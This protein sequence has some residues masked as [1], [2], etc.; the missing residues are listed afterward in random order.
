MEN[1]SVI[2]WDTVAC[3]ITSIHEIMVV[4]NVLAQPRVASALLP[5]EYFPYHLCRG[6]VWFAT[7]LANDPPVFPL[8]SWLSVQPHLTPNKLN[9]FRPEPD[10][11]V[12]AFSK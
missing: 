6:N 7:R 2:S 1:S 11:E 5:G 9:C 8:W 4:G 10:A 12:S 3:R